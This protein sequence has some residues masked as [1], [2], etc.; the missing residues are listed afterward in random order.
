MTDVFKTD[1]RIRAVWRYAETLI[2][3]RSPGMPSVFVLSFFFLINTLHIKFILLLKH[4]LS[5][6][7][8][9]ANAD[10]KLVYA[11]F[12]DIVNVANVTRKRDDSP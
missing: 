9:T 5:V 10:K 1:N 2:L 8:K 11:S 12:A 4:A 7:S 6:F 3:S